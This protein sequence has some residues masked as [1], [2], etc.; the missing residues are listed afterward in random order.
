MPVYTDENM[1]VILQMPA[2]FPYT[3]LHA[4]AAL[5]ADTQVFVPGFM[6]AP[7]GLYSPDVY[8]FQRRV[9]DVEF[10]ILPDRNLASRMARVSMGEP[11]D[12]DRRLAAGVMAFAQ[13]LD[14][15][16]EPSI[17]FHELAHRVNNATALEELRW[18][19]AADRPRPQDWVDVALGRLNRM[20]PQ[21]AVATVPDAN[22]ARPLRRWNRNYILALKVAE[23]ELERV[24]ALDKMLQ[25]MEWMFWDFIWAGPALLYAS[26]YLAPS[27]PKKGMFKQLRSA[28]RKRA[29]AGVRNAAWDMTHMSEFARLVMEQGSDQK[30]F[31]LATL[32]RAVALIAP[33]LFGDKEETDER[34]AL[35][36]ALSEWWPSADAWTLADAFWSYSERREDPKRLVNRESPPNH[37]GV[38]I[39]AG[40]QHLRQWTP[41]SAGSAAPQVRRSDRIQR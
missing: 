31:I 21:S 3:D 11:V 35:S 32:D 6:L 17:A 41:S 27:S 14:L 20:A 33:Y 37:I 28:D 12:K 30:R 16:Y 9:E 26:L 25:L 4:V 2:D 15:N 34:K 8:L 10:V 18:F 24:S 7:D 5:L 39:D 29:I 13:C 38:L 22:M 23:L 36:A 1:T 19:R 40:E